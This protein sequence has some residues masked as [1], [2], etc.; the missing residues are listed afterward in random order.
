MISKFLSDKIKAI[1]FL[2]MIM[3][4]FLHSYNLKIKFTTETALI[5]KGYNSF[6]QNLISEG[7][8][9][10]AVP[11]FFI[12]SGYLFFLSI[13]NGSTSEFFSK[14]RKRY[15]TLVLPYLLWSIY[16]LLFFLF[17]Q[18]IPFSKPFFTNN[19]IID[20]SLKDWFNSIFLN[21]IPYQLWFIRDLIVL[22]IFSPI[23][24]WLVK[25]FKVYIICI[26]L[27]TWLFQFDYLIFSNEALLFFAL[28]AFFGIQKI[29]IQKIKLRKKNAMVCMIWVLLVFIKTYLIYVNVEN[30]WLIRILHKSSILVGIA[31][32]WLLY[33]IIFEKKDIE[34]SKCYQLFQYSFFLFAFH[35]PVLTIF[36]KGF[37][38]VL[39]QSQL[40][41]FLIYFSAPVITILVSVIVGTLTKKYIPQGYYLMTG[42]R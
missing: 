7:I 42:G 10:V 18:L 36:K 14:F 38:Y 6:I 26:F 2:L 15:K 8:T 13:K 32:I 1:S 19:L 17:L 20:Y 9:R 37:Y 4:V 33:D 21:P 39:G 28:G 27:I 11:L 5:E 35:E 25:Y 41:S 34:K 3:V 12:I 24:Y 30:E 22:I 40:S 29:N 31:S 23:L 16:G